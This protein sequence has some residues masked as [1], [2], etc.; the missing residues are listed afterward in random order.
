MNASDDI[1]FDREEIEEIAKAL[2]EAEQDLREFYEL[3]FKL[4]KYDAK[5]MIA[6]YDA[7]LSGDQGATDAL[8]NEIVTLIGTLRS[9]IE[10]EDNK[11]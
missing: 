9:Q 5:I 10:S 6:A 1:P 8:W 4:S 2:D 7:H 11:G 3:T